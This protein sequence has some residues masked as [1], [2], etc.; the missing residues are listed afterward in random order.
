MDLQYSS[1][2][3]NNFCQLE[4]TVRFGGKFLSSTDTYFIE[5]IVC[6]EFFASTLVNI[7]K[8]HDPCLALM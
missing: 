5:H 6:A 2:I 8:K 7:L 1:F 3:L 4:L